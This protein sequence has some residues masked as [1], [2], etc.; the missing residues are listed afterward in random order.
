MAE[1]FKR[2]SKLKGASVRTRQS[3][4]GSSP[5]E[6]V[7]LTL[8][9]GPFQSTGVS[10]SCQPRE[11]GTET[12][13]ETLCARVDELIRSHKGVPLLSTTGSRALI[14]ELAARSEGLEEAIRQ[15]ALEAQKVAASQKGISDPAEAGA[16]A[17]AAS[18]GAVGETG[19]V[20]PYDQP[21]R[22]D[23]QVVGDRE[24]ALTV[25]TPQTA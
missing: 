17:Q 19:V 23:S 12:L 22:K 11:A 9:A 1:L 16:G 7:R 18:L 4:A 21:H 10:S 25:L 15:I 8:I 24:E 6:G 14:E 13:D 5:V 2:I 3:E 20:S